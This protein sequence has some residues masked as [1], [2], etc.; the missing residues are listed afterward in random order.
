[1]VFLMWL[2]N[3]RFENKALSPVELLVLTIVKD[4]TV[5]A[6]TI[7]NQLKEDMQN[8]WKPERGTI[9]PVL[10]RLVNMN[11]LERTDPHKLEFKRSD[12]G[13]NFLTSLPPRAFK[14][15]ME[16]TV[17]Y[18]TTLSDQIIDINP[19]LALTILEDFK[20]EL[21]NTIERVSKLELK[22]KKENETWF[23]ISVD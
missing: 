12:F 6:S 16:A 7:I 22:A 2:Q 10:H 21:Q 9:Y 5:N 13:R 11:L 3:F 8:I 1:M 23:D 19:Q 18:L 15:Q 20:K 17:M 14:S 4:D